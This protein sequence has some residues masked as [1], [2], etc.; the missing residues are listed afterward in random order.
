MWT[1]GKAPPNLPPGVPPLLPNPYIMAPGLLHAYPVSPNPYHCHSCF[2]IMEF[3]TQFLTPHPQPQVYG[4]DDLQMLQTRIPLVS[5][6]LLAGVTALCLMLMACSNK[7]IHRPSFQDYYSI[8]FATPQTAL[9]GRDG[10][11]TSNPYSGKTFYH[12]NHHTFLALS[13]SNRL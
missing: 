7:M 2:H 3:L 4:Y 9:T 1:T 11:L 12:P 6:V 8:P 5:L 13:P 10:S